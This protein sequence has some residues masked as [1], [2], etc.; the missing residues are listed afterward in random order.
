MN[1]RCTLNILSFEPI[2][3]VLLRVERHSGGWTLWV[4]HRHYGGL[5]EDCAPA[6]Y[7]R[8]SDAELLDV[9]DAE[10]SSWSARPVSFD[11]F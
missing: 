7:E 10:A 3:G 5:F 4:R 8:L 11:L 9:L 6:E 1:H 2:A